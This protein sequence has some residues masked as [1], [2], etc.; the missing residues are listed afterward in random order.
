VRGWNDS[1]PATKA[2]SEGQ[3]RSSTGDTALT[4]AADRGNEFAVRELVAA[5][6]ELGCKNEEGLTALQI[7]RDR[8]VGHKP[9]HDRI[10][11]FLRS[12]TEP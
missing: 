6:A 7:A 9:E 1:R 12:L 8:A 2:W 11:A 5:G 3:L 4:M 10:F